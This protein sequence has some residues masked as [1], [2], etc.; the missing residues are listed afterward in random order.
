MRV[1]EVSNYKDF[2]HLEK[3][4]N[5]VLSRSCNTV[6]S[7][8]EWLST[9]W[10]HFGDDKKLLLLLAEE[11]GKIMGIAP[12]MYSLYKMFGLRQAKIEF[13][14]TPNSDYNDFI[15]ADKKEQCVKSFI[16]YLYDLPEKWNCIDLLDIPEDS[17]S[18]P[19]LRELTKT[20]KPHDACPFVGLPKSYE[21]LLDKLSAKQRK[22]IRNGFRRLEK[23]F[24]VDFLDY[25]AGQSVV[26]GMNTFFDLHQKRWNAVG[27]PGFFGNQKARRF[28]LDV[29]RSFSQKGWLGLFLLK[30]SGKTVAA[31]YGYKYLGKFSSY[32]SGYDPKYSQYSI[33]NLLTAYVMRNCIESEIV[34][35]DFM[36]G[37]EEYKFHWNA[38]TRWNHQAFLIKKGFWASSENRLYNEYWIQ[39]KKLKH[40]MNNPQRT[41]ASALK[42]AG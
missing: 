2:V 36:R 17:Q 18:L 26:E 7:S 34:E 4:W 8:W 33:G 19:L 35:F 10:K 3:T 13:I 29:S 38:L 20:L 22:H 30:L 31:Y 6:F 25:S 15:L 32:L 39:G 27:L 11:N 37:A 28:H 40:I 42:R 16:E 41:L 21:A 24:K 23:D 5:D 9:W 1:V 14:G 12:L